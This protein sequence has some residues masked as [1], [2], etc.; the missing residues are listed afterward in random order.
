MFHLRDVDS[1][2]RTEKWETDFNFFSGLKNSNI[3]L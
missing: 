3:L 2:L 1:T